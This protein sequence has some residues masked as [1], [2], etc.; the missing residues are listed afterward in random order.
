MKS[1]SQKTK[2][3]RVSLMYSLEILLS[4]WMVVFQVWSEDT[5]METDKTESE[6]FDT[7]LS[8]QLQEIMEEEVQQTDP[9]SKD[10]S[11]S[12]TL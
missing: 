3:G 11:V 1:S 10:S 5:G 12:H 9:P 4:V 6:D 7:Q 2:T 8:L